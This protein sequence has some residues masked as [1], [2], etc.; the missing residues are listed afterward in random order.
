[1]TTILRDGEREGA[2][3]IADAEKSAGLLLHAT[4]RFHHPAMVALDEG[5]S[6]LKQLDAMIDLLIAGLGR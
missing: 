3:R 4:S 1:M 5:K 2:W 6:D